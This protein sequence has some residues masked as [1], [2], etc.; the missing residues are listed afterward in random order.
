MI[1]IDVYMRPP[2]SIEN[3]EACLVQHIVYPSDAENFPIGSNS[4]KDKSLAL[5][6]MGPSQETV[7]EPCVSFCFHGVSILSL[8]GP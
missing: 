2:R 6:Q 4:S 5:R 7:T 3:V 8:G 1:K